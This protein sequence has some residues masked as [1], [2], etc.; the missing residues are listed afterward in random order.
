MSDQFVVIWCNEGIEGVIPVTEIER[1]VMWDTL[2]GEEA[3]STVSQS[4]NMA[5]L[6]ARFNTQR[7]YEI[8]AIEAEDGITAADIKDMFDVEPQCAADTI[9]KIGYK[10]HSDRQNSSRIKIQ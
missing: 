9:R 10:I 3:K 1:K 8:Y 5:I 4:I 2:K 6:R 7:A